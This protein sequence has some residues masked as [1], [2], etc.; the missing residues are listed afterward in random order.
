MGSSD[1]RPW[2]A[3]HACACSRLRPPTVVNSNSFRH[4]LSPDRYDSNVRHSSK[5]SADFVV[6]PN[7]ETLHRDDFVMVE[8]M[9]KNTVHSTS[10]AQPAVRHRRRLRAYCGQTCPA[11]RR[12]H[13]PVNRCG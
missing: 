9:P 3:Q 6:R 10:S 11:T 12:S 5:P 1:G 7:G 8:H 4:K 13:G 2:R